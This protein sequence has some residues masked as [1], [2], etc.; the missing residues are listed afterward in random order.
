MVLDMTRCVTIA[1]EIVSAKKNEDC[2]ADPVDR[3]ICCGDTR[4]AI[5]KADHLLHRLWTSDTFLK[6][7]RKHARAMYGD[8]LS[9][10]RLANHPLPPRSKS[11]RQSRVEGRDRFT[12][13]VDLLLGHAAILSGATMAT[14]L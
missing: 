10:C 6:F 1:G 7:A 13:L 5:G 4:K 2:A 3:Q 9:Y 14:L 11:S 8:Y 12:I